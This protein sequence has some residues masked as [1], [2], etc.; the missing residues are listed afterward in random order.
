MSTEV[1]TLG[2]SLFILGTYPSIPICPTSSHSNPMLCFRLQDMCPVQLSGRKL[3]PFDLICTTRRVADRF[4]P[5]HRQSPLSEMY[6]R[7]ISVV[8]PMFIFICFTAATATAANLQTIMITR[9]FAGVM[10]SS[11][12]TKFASN[13]P[14][15]LDLL[16]CVFRVACNDGWRRLGGSL[17]TARARYGGRIL[18][19]RRGRGAHSGADHRRSSVT[20]LSR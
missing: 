9:F 16:D 12:S 8:V 11:V 20:E 4:S 7:R 15:R 13:L 18:L 17:R 1:T 6:G 14:L 19:A 2:L 3:L 10:A 5:N